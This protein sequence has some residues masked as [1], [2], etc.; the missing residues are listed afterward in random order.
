[1][2]VTEGIYRDSRYPERHAGADAGIQHPVWQCCYN[3]R[4]DL[5]VNDAAASALLAVMGICTSP[6]ERMPAVVNL[7]F[8]PDMGRMTA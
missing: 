4:L 3:I 8:T 7:N 2:Q 5:N 6:M 1:M